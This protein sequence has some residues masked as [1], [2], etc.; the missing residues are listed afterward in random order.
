MVTFVAVMVKD[1]DG[2]AANRGTPKI[3]TVTRAQSTA[4]RRT[5]CMAKTFLRVAGTR[6]GQLD[7]T[8]IQWSGESERILRLILASVAGILDR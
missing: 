4:R 6:P 8:Q 1:G 7:G 3:V 5:L 2:V